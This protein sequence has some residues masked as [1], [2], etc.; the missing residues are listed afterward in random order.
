MRGGSCPFEIGDGDLA[1]DAVGDGL[2]HAVA[3]EGCG[4]AGAL[5]IEFGWRHRQRHV[6]RKHQFDVDGLGG[7]SVQRRQREKRAA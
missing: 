7:A 3:G 6:D 4:I 5:D 1:V 2:D